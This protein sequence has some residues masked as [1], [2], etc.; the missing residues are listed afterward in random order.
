MRRTISAEE[1]AL[2]K[3]TIRACDR[4]GISQKVLAL[5]IGV[6]GPT[7]SRMR[8]GSFVLTRGRGKEVNFPIP[9]RSRNARTDLISRFEQGL[10]LASDK[11]YILAL[12]RSPAEIGPRYAAEPGLQV[13][14]L[15]AE[16]A[17][18]RQPEAAIVCAELYQ[19]IGCLADELGVIDHP[20]VQRA[21]DNA[22]AHKLV[23]RNLLPWP[24]QPL[25]S[26]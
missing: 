21:L 14:E 7:V 13:D 9:A 18:L 20:D 15:Q 5:A 23:H 17:L 24:R 3:I 11:H 25:R 8:D 16:N 12:L 19:V 1:V 4:F 26:P 2:T 10:M 22:G 6:S